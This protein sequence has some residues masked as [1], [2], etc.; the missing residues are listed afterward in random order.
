MSLLLS[1][2]A[3]AAELP[4]MTLPPP[5]LVVTPAIDRRPLERELFERATPAKSV[6]P[7][8]SYVSD[9]DYPATALRQGE[10]GTVEFALRVGK[11]GRASGCSILSPPASFGLEFTT[12]RLLT[13]RARF[14]AARDKEGK[15]VEGAVTG[16]I[17]WVLPPATG[18]VPDRLTLRFRLLPGGEVV[19]CV[20]EV[21]VDGRTSR[22]ERKDCA[23]MV[24]PAEIVAAIRLQSDAASPQVRTELRLVRSADGPLPDLGGTGARILSRSDARVAVEVDGK[25]SDCTVV[26]AMSLM[27]RDLNPC[28]PLMTVGGRR[29]E[30]RTDMRLIMATLIEGEGAKP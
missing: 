4:A 11:D 25:V 30:R 27:G 22:S 20:G 29:L 2:A 18:R 26:E 9:H 8:A 12:C 13:A 5:P 24:P 16:R 10:Q 6:A 21:E 1:L 19:N 15:A 17:R 3:Q 7:L 14:E 23:A 28:R